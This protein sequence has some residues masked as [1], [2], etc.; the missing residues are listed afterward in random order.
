MAFRASAGRLE[1]SAIF[2]VLVSDD[3]GLIREVF[4]RYAMF[5]AVSYGV[6][7]SIIC[8]G[9]RSTEVALHFARFFN[10]Y[11]AAF[12]VFGPRL[13]SAFVQIEGQRVAK[14]QV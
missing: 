4:R 14:F 6:L 11:A 9:V 8:P 2:R 5:R 3:R 10:R 13:T 1:F 12:H 7:T